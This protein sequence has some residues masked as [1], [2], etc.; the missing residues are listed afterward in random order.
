M[1]LPRT[2]LG[3][4]RRGLLEEHGRE[5]QPCRQP[6]EHREEMV[7]GRR[8]RFLDVD[9]G[10]AYDLV[11]RRV[12]WVDQGMC[13]FRPSFPRVPDA[14]EG[15]TPSS[16]RSGVSKSAIGVPH[17]RDEAEGNEV[18]VGVAWLWCVAGCLAWWV[19]VTWAVERVV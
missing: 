19:L 16:R 14:D 17:V 18:T 10:Q 9:I 5:P 4:P 3:D 15:E 1:P 8:S 13:G 12:R 6:P 11:T 7:G 2:E